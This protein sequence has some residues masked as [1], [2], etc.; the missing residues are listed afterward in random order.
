M[1]SLFLASFLF[2]ISSAFG[3][4]RTD[5]VPLSNKITQ[6]SAANTVNMPTRNWEVERS[7]LI[8][9]NQEPLKPFKF[10][11]SYKDVNIDLKDGLWSNL[12]SGQQIWTIAI[13]SF[14]ARSLN[15]VWSDFFLPEGSALFVYNED[16]SEIIGAYTAYSGHIVPVIPVI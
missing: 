6:T 13:Q 2:F 9:Y 8:S 16:K 7:K 5:L 12:P 1:K 10:G 15:V 11:Y 4:L 14:G 3:Q